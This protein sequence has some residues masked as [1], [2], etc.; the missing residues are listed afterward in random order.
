MKK[1]P[2]SDSVAIVYRTVVKKLRYKE[3]SADEWA[4]FSDSKKPLVL[5]KIIA[6][7]T[8][9]K[10]YG[11][12]VKVVEPFDYKRLAREGKDY[13]YE[14]YDNEEASWY[15]DAETAAELKRTITHFLGSVNTTPK[16]AT[17]QDIDALLESGMIVSVTLVDG[18]SLLLLEMQGGGYMTDASTDGDFTDH[19]SSNEL[20]QLM[21]GDQ[22]MSQVVGYNLRTVGLRL[23]QY[24]IRERPT[25]SRSYAV[26]LITEGRILVNDQQSK[27]G[28]KLRESDRITIDY[29]ESTEPEVPVVELPVLYEDND[30]IVINKPA[31]VL[32]HNKGVRHIEATV[33]SF[34]RSRTNLL[35]GERP[36]I[37]HRLDRATSGVIICAKTPEALSWLQKQFHDRHAVKTY[38]AVVKGTPAIAQALIDMPI[39]RNPKAP[40]TFRVG[41]NG[42]TAQTKYEVIE[43]S[44]KY[45]LLELTPRTGRTHQLRVHLAYQKH[46]IVGDKLYAGPEADRMYLHA[47]K[48]EITL[49]GGETKTFVAPVPPEFKTILG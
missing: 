33:A 27:G 48:L 39:E 11:L 15:D 3:L 19:L 24:V 40:A 42:K 22:N 23:D 46:P 1:F 41:P 34:V 26:R 35:T 38:S 36:G 17:L 5:R 31:G 18:Q 9:A 8:L 30:C 12:S 13:L 10:E 28:Y 4:S 2:F 21:G 25:L 44:S 7:T 6:L 20:W 43:S 47:H 16:R 32:T 14:L 49:P 37:V 45:S 29:D